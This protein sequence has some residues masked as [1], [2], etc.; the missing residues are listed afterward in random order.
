M[1]CW[2]EW[3]WLREILLISRKLSLSS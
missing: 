1:N 2:R 3:K